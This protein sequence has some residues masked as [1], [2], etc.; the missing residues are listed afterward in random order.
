MEHSRWFSKCGFVRLVKGD[1]FIGECMIS[2]PPE[3]MPECPPTNGRAKISDETLQS[4]MT[5]IEVR[6]ALS[7]GIDPTRI[8]VALKKKWEETGSGKKS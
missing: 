2:R 3:G 4:L 1:E 5:S 8:K 6:E 7:H